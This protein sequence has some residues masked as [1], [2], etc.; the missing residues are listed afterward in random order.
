MY[1]FVCADIYFQKGLCKDMTEPV[2]APNLP[3]FR[4]VEMYTSVVEQTQRD[5]ILQHF[6]TESQ[7]R[8]VIATVAFG[9]G[10][11]CSD[12]RQVVHVGPPN[13]I[14]SYIQETGRVCR[15]GEQSLATLLSVKGFMYTSKAIKEYVQNTTVCR[16]D[17]YSVF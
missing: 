9:M 16:R 10:V 4:L 11:D 5:I 17:N 14:E 12:V 15:S 1:S 13:D 7:L 3:E 6:T 8:I 2:D